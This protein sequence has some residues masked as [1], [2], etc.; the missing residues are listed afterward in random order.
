MLKLKLPPSAIFW[1]PDAKSR[2]IGKAPDTRKD[3][4]Q[5]EKGI[6]ED[7][8]VGWHCRLNGHEFE[9]A[10]EMVKDREAW[11]VAVHEVSKSQT[12]LSDWTTYWVSDSIQPSHTLWP[13]SPFAFNLSQWSFPMSQFFASGS[14][15]IGVSASTSDLPMNVKD[16]FP[17][18]WTGWIPLQSKGLSRVFSSTTVQKHQFFSTQL[19][20]PA[21]TSIYDYWKNHSLD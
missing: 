12:K 11:H 15:R 20:S 6:T 10:L 5:E 8:L 14:Q 17:L 4:V 13:S 19:Y 9:Q 16:W 18:G 7:E 2:L 1:P 21:L 3:W